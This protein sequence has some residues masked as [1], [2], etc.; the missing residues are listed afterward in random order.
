MPAIS[1]AANSSRIAYSIDFAG[2]GYQELG[3]GY[4]DLEAEFIAIQYG[5]S[6][7]IN[8]WSR[9]LDTRQYDGDKLVSTPS[10]RT[11]RP[12]PP[13]IEIKCSNELVVKHLSYQCSITGNKIGRLAQA[14]WNQTKN[15]KVH[16]SWIRARENPA[17][18]LLR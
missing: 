18:K 6:E 3:P 4:T 2:G 15:L 16:Y 17:V 7:F 8:K 9:E 10:D 11:Q 5:L 1:I 13:P 12:L 14:I